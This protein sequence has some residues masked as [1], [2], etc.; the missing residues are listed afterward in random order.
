MRSG[1]LS[2]VRPI[3]VACCSGLVALLL[4]GAALAQGADAPE[5]KLERVQITGSS[6]KRIDG[7]TALPVQILTREDIARTG[8]TNAEQL[9]KTVTATS[10]L[11]AT[12]V[13]NSGAGG[14][15]GSPG[16]SVSLVSLR[17]LG[18]TRTLVLINGR[19]AAPAAGSNAVDIATIPITMI[20]R[21]EVLKDGASAVYGSDAVAGVVNFILRRDFQGTEVATTVGS[22]TRHGGGLDTKVSAISGFGNFDADRYSV[23]IGADYERTKSILGSDRSF[24]TNLDVQHR[25]D[26]T[27]TTAFPANILTNSGAIRSPTY[28]NCAPSEISPLNPGLCRFDNAPSI[29]LQPETKLE[30]VALNGRF[31]ISS[32]VEAYLETSYTR[33]ETRTVE[34]PVLF[35][36]AVQPA[37]SPYITDLNNLLATQYPSFTALR[38]LVT[39][40]AYALLPPTSS[41]YPTA[42]AAAN[43]LTGQPLVLLFRSYPNGLRKTQDISQ[44]SRFVTGLRG[45]ALGW[46]Y[47]AGFL[48]SKDK[49]TQNLTGGWALTDQ[50]LNLVNT[51]VINPFGPTASQAALDAAQAANYNGVLTVSTTTVTGVDLK[52]SRELMV[53]PAGAVSLAAGAEFRREQLNLEPSDANKRFLIAGFGAPG[54]PVSA[55]RNIESAYAEINVPIFKGFEADAAGRYDNYERVGKTFNPKGSL[56]FQPIEQLL[57][58]ASY[59]KGFRAP[60]L[61]DLYQPA[62]RGISTNG[63]RDFV[64]CPIGFSGIIDCSTQFVTI[65]GGNPALKPEKSKSESLGVVFEPTKDYS[66]GA[67]VFYVQVKDTI[68]TGLSVATILSDP[69][70]YAGYITRGAPDGNA[71]GQGPILGIS[72]QLTNLGKTN[73]SGVDLDLLGRVYNTPGDKLTLR[74]DGT[75]FTRYDT[76][77]LDGS[78]SNAINNPAASLIGIGVVL[79]WRHAASVSWDHGP[80]AATFQHNYQVGYA[81]LNTS[82]QP[83]SNPPRSVGSYTTLDAQVAYTGIKN[84][85]L[86]LGVKNLADKDPPYTNYGAG[87]VGGYD[88]SYTDVRGRFVYLTATYKFL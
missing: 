88:L 24:A 64:R 31:K 71:S 53:L 36:G 62:A 3:G 45:T 69:V 50:Y 74:L 29:S 78:Y 58:R 14:N 60:T 41:Y 13:A 57:F 67:N 43:G 18:S 73:V 6:I 4:T 10:G 52:G 48:Y 68:R 1:M 35:N 84:A 28:P 20:D 46:D 25:L 23:M 66:L 85:K 82:L 61:V 26:K 79:R 8:A 70:R 16:G 11:G 40:R 32:A 63:S 56:R 86:A 9:L 15:Q 54:V 7:E 34:Q 33:N 17:G 44:D 72:Q 75:Y 12:S 39:G 22:P 47:D 21:V 19:R 81:D 30:N 83:A 2:A 65:G 51:G 42:F 87:F 5:T 38:T 49:I 76:Q 37:G 77:N 27:S 59:G 80:F 55:A